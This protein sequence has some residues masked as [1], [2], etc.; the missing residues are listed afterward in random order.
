M[1]TEQAAEYLG[2]TKRRVQ[3]MIAREGLP[4]VKIGRDWLIE[5]PTLE[6]FKQQRAAANEG[7]PG[8]PYRV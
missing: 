3:Q 2:V 8:R 4:A 7:K 1:N 5:R 6:S